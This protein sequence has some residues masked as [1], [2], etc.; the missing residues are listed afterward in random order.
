ME[1]TNHNNNWVSIMQFLV[2]AVVNTVGHFTLNEALQSLSFI[3]GCIGGLFIALNQATIY[4]NN[5]RK[6]N[7]KKNTPTV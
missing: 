2:I 7:G 3:I 6:N 1:P 5:K 4:F